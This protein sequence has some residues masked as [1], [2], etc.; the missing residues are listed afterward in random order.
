MKG[1]SMGIDLENMGVCIGCGMMTDLTEGFFGGYYI[2]CKDCSEDESFD[3]DIFGVISWV[4]EEDRYHKLNGP[5][6]IYPSG[7]KE[8]WIDGM[9]YD[10][11]D[12]HKEVGKI[13][14]KLKGI[15]E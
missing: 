11:L 10:E 15:G 2:V 9:E 13:R 7:D 3:V 4:N 14:K 6:I 5:A 8:Y 1:E 12:F